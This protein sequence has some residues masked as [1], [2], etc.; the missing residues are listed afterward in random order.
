[1]SGSELEEVIWQNRER[2]RGTA[3][4]GVDEEQAVGVTEEPPAIL[5]AAQAKAES[6]TLSVVMS[7]RTNQ[8]WKK[9]KSTWSLGYN[10]HS[11]QTRRRCKKVVR[12]KETENAKLREG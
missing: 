12:D 10:S 4:V 1:M 9:A 11:S 2:L 3:G 8:E 6:N 5:K 7:Q